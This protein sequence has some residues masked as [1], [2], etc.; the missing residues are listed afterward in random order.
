MI[1]LIK[2]DI[3]RICRKKSFKV[4]MFFM[5]FFQFVDVLFVTGETADQIIENAQSRL[6]IIHLMFITVFI[7]L[8]TAADEKKGNIRAANIAFGFGRTKFMFAKF[9]EFMLLLMIFYI[10]MT[11]LRIFFYKLLEVPLSNRQLSLIAVYPVFAVIHGIICLMIAELAELATDSIAVGIITLVS[12]VVFLTIILRTVEALY[13]INLYS[14]V[15]GGLLNDAFVNITAGRSP[16]QL[17]PVLIY[18]IVIFAATAALF[19]KKEM[20]L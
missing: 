8:C 11:P 18:V 19:G 10:F 9:L 7:F 6:G 17:I 4:L 13:K 14:F 12:I 1:G 15:P 5:L 3:R 20:Q 16:W 2:A